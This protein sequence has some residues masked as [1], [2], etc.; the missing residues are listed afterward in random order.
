MLREC[1]YVHRIPK[2]R[3]A[4][5]SCL[6]LSALV[7]RVFGFSSEDKE[8]HLRT[9]SDPV[10]GLLT[11]YFRG[12]GDDENRV[13]N[14]TLAILA[15]KHSTPKDLDCNSILYIALLWWNTQDL[16]VDTITYN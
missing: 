15:V 13:E 9:L 4:G 14:S 5:A 16:E 12:T 3:S 8:R 7:F 10:S 6:L 2:E 1:L 11:M